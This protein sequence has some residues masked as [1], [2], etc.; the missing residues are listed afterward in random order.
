MAWRIWCMAGAALLLVGC[1]A[2]PKR[3]DLSGRILLEDG[4]LGR[5]IQMV[6]QDSDR[7]DGDLLR[8]RTEIRNRTDDDL[9]VDVQMVWKDEQGYELYATNWAPLFLPAR[10]VTKHEVAS[11]RPDVVDYELRLRNPAKPVETD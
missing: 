6:R 5:V 4:H 2:N 10:Y 9:W 3:A 8:V 7:I 11:L 1:E